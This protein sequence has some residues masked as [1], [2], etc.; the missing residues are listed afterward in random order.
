MNETIA[1]QW[2]FTALGACICAIGWWIATTLASLNDKMERVLV[3]IESHEAHLETH[4][5][6][7]KRLEGP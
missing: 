5:A 6:R 2:A 4:E 1:L 7:L 3:R